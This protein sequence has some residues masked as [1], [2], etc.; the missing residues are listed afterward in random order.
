MRICWPESQEPSTCRTTTSELVTGPQAALRTV[1][2]VRTVDNS[3]TLG[4]DSF[5]HRRTRYLRT[6]AHPARRCR[7]GEEFEV[8]AGAHLLD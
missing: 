5:S 2:N 8:R 6:P 1:A 4:R 7:A 3:G